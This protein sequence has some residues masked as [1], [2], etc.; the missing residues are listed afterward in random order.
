MGTLIGA[1]KGADSLINNHDKLGKG[2]Y[3]LHIAL[4]SG[5]TLSRADD[6]IIKQRNV[7]RA[8]NE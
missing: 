5:T 6:F 1:T 8:E 3:K 2:Q 4:L 7:P